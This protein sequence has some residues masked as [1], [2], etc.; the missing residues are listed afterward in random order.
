[1][2]NTSTKPT[3]LKGDLAHLPPALQPLVSQDHWVLWRWEF[4]N[5]KWTK[6]PYSAANPGTGAKTDDPKTWASHKAAIAAA[7]AMGADGVGFVLRGTALDVVDLDHCLDPATGHPDA[8]AQAWLETA[9]GAYVERTPSGEGL[10]I[11]GGAGANAEKL[12]R[13]WS[14]ND[15]RENAGIEIYRNCERY[16]TVTGLQQGDCKELPPL[17][18]VLDRIKAHYDDAKTKTRAR[19]NSNGSNSKGF[20]FNQA[21]KAK[22]IDYD[23][24]IRTGAPEGQRSELFHSCVLHLAAKHMSVDQ[25]VDELARH[26]NGIARK[27][28]ADKRLRAEV[29][30][31]YDKWKASR[32]ATPSSGTS[33]TEPEEPAIWDTVDKNRIPTP[34]RTN[35]RRA[36]RALQIKCRY[37]EFHDVLLVEGATFKRITN[38]DHSALML[39]ARMHKAFGF[40]PGPRYTLDAM[41]QIALEN[42]FD[43]VADY[44]NALTWDGVPRLEHWLATYLG[45]VDSELNCAFGRI[46]LI[47]AVRRVR[48]PGCKFDPI[49]VLEGPMG[50]QKSK[51]IET[52]A[53]TENFSDQT[54]LGA[55]DREAQEL[56]AGVWLFEIAEL[57]NIRRTEVESIKAFAS[58]TYDRAR[59]VYGRTR[60]DQPRRCVLFA[61]TNDDQYLKVPDRRFWPVR[62][63][64][65]N[66]EALRRDRDQLWAEA[67]QRERE[68]VSIVLDHKLWS[69]AYTEQEAREEYD[70]WLDELAKVIGE[71]GQGEER[72]ASADLL[73]T[74]LGIHVSKLRDIDYKR[75]GRCMRRLGWIGPKLV[76]F[77]QEVVKGYTRPTKTKASSKTT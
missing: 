76:R 67:A 13:R 5:D 70:P 45:A 8:W 25:I 44:L 77:G 66:I 50:T 7:K 23:E 4:R 33:E 30:R 12:H 53:G 41:I 72:V 17:D 42:R 29:E 36:L 21:S 32:A 9:S 3:A 73:K 57:S 28:A 75:L 24:V 20:D 43:P 58:R 34:T 16:I 48:H 62:T 26:P 51:T 69:S 65:I 40:D 2:P 10:R 52:L 37:D 38:L 56:L 18:P 46:A 19:S 64:T 11:I 27:Y 22:T 39:C 63:A 15:A 49:I 68:G 54:I 6:P 71:K 35:A 60:V 14:V 59:P 47:A 31:S 61:T 55:R 74:V 1:M